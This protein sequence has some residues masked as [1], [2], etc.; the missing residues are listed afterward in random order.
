MSSDSLMTR[1][2]KYVE[3]AG[4]EPWCPSR[5]ACRESGFARHSSTN[6]VNG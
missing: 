4:R 5:G 1:G 6:F 3:C 2:V